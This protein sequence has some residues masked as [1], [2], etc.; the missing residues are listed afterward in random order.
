MWYSFSLM[1]INYYGSKHLSLYISLH[2]VVI[3]LP[4][5]QFIKI[6]GHIS[7]QP[8]G[9]S[10]NESSPLVIW[11]LSLDEATVVLSGQQ[12]TTWTR[13]DVYTFRLVEWYCWWLKS[14]DH[15]LR[16][17]VYPNIYWFFVSQVVQD[18]SHQQVLTPKINLIF[19]GVIPVGGEPKNAC[20]CM[21]IILQE[22]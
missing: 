8:S 15:Q 17:V 11:N 2:Q 16:L 14:S 5:L 9:R 3:S 22:M 13:P 7:L 12:A 4:S 6:D 21:W 20:G 18:F 19:L 1:D 10:T